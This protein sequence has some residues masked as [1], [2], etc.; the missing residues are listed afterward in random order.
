MI[1]KNSKTTV[2][3]AKIF[4]IDNKSLGNLISHL[5]NEVEAK[6]NN[7]E[8]DSR[9]SALKVLKVLTLNSNRNIKKRKSLNLDYGL[10][11]KSL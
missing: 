11:M 9:K 5:N 2:R 7:E 1:V 3:N 6:V 10:S 8:E 4:V